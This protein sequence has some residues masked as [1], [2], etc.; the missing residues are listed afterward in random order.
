MK[1]G[2]GMHIPVRSLVIGKAEMNKLEMDVWKDRYVPAV[3]R[4]NGQSTPVLVRY[5]GSHTR[6]YPKRSFEIVRK[7]QTFHYN[8]EFDD[9]SM[10]RNALSF[11]F[12]ELLGL[13]SP[14]TKHVQLVRNGKPLGLYLEI[15]AVEPGF[16]RRRGIGARSL[17]YAVNS[18]ADFSL[19][20]PASQLSGY[21]YRFGGSCEKKR[22]ASFIRGLHRVRGTRLA[23][24]LNRNLDIDNY[25]K[26]LTGAVLTGNYDGFEQNYAL[27]RHRASGKWRIIPWDYEGT[28]GRNCYGKLV[29]SDLV[30]VKGYNELTK[31]VLQHRPYRLRYKNMLRKAL[32]GAFN[33]KKILAKATDMHR[34]ISPYVR[35]DEYFQWPY[36]EFLGELDVIR[37]YI[38]ERRAIV[39]SALKQL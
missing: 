32:N 22:L 13:P 34:S 14:R 25:L 20:S 6:E 39:A 21:E 33:E 10:I 11:W 7:G 31:K 19:R 12:L 3:L 9:P 26:W 35:K 24:Y 27:Y 1:G 2:D 30:D 15:E 37:N 16:F 29:E 38:R 28:W 4:T 18:H 5:R 36:D 17:F 8:A 23:A